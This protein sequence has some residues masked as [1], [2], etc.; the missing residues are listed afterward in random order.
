MT[1]EG[2]S[3]FVED[4]NVIQDMSCTPSFK[5]NVPSVSLLDICGVTVE[6]GGSPRLRKGNTTIPIHSR[7]GLYY[8]DLYSPA[9]RN[10]APVYM[11][12]N[13]GSYEQ[14]DEY[15]VNTM[16]DEENTTIV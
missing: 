2:L 4:F 10:V 8:I 5:I 3:V 11:T 15:Y 12:E 14:D 13:S 7:E 9:T 1:D 6:L 16:I